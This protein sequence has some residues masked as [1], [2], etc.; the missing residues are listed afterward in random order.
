MP[1]F[2]PQTVRVDK[3]L[4]RMQRTKIHLAVVLD[5]FG[6][7]A[8]MA[9]MEDIVEQLIGAVEDEFD[10]ETERRADDGDILEGL[11]SIGDAI[12]RF[13]DPGIK[14]VSNTIGGYVTER[15]ERIPIVGDQAIFGTYDVIVESMDEMRVARVRFVRRE[16]PDQQSRH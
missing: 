2:I 5:E 6:G 11:T 9:T 14:P 3:V 1:L 4:E 8:G 16:Q 10:V 7:M 13:G 12:E 15:L